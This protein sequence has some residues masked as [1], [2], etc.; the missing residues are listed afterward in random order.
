MKTEKLRK[1]KTY[2]RHKAYISCVPKNIAPKIFIRR[3]TDETHINK[4]VGLKRKCPYFG[5]D[6]SQRLNLFTN[7]VN[8]RNELLQAD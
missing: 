2:K 8:P 5:H 6:F 7:S 3:I 1:R 4:Y